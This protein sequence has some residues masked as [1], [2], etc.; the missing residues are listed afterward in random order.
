M[1]Y[2]PIIISGYVMMMRNSLLLLLLTGKAVATPYLGMVL[3]FMALGRF[4]VSETAIKQNQNLKLMRKMKSN[5]P[6]HKLYDP[7]KDGTVSIIITLC[8]YYLFLSV[9]K[10][11]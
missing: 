3:V 2:K 8:Y 1:T 4:Q 5:I 6:N 10:R 9:V 11:S 7:N